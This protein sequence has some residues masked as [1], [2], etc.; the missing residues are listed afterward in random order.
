MVVVA[1]LTFVQSWGDYLFTLTMIDSPEK[2]TLSVAISEISSWSSALFQSS[3][4]ATYGAQ[5]AGQVLLMAPVIVVFVILQR[6]F[7]RG[8]QEG[9]LKL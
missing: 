8:L 7:I 4:F 3:A 9:A 2:M 6:W 5:A 1:I